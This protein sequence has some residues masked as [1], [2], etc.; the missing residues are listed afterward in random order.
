MD[1]QEVREQLI[2]LFGMQLKFNKE[3]IEII[4][5]NHNCYDDTRMKFGYK[6]S[7]YYGS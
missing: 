5:D 2:K 1:A 6:I 4:L 3:F 7:S